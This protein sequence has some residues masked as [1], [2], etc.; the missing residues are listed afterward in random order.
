MRLRYDLRGLFQRYL[1][2]STGAV[3]EYPVY[4]T[5]EPKSVS[6]GCR[7]SS[8]YQI[9]FLFQTV[10]FRQSVGCTKPR[11]E[12]R[13][14]KIDREFVSESSPK[15]LGISQQSGL[16][17]DP[18]QVTQPLSWEPFLCS[19]FL[20]PRDFFFFTTDIHTSDARASLFS[21]IV[22]H[23]SKW[24]PLLK[25]GSGA[26]NTSPPVRGAEVS[27]SPAREEVM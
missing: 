3:Q 26:N 12:K 13:S 7:L 9:L 16:S 6:G 8:H 24:T 15:A 25:P 22:Q 18:S 2:V 5:H 19:Y 4:L 10:P 1:I 17:P 14:P 21:L 11:S 23:V 20:A 27:G